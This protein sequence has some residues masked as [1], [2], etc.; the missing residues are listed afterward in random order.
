MPLL[1]DDIDLTT[2]QATAKTVDPKFFS[3][4]LTGNGK[5]KTG[6][7]HSELRPADKAG[8]T[9]YSALAIDHITKKASTTQHGITVVS[10]PF[11]PV[12]RSALTEAG[13][14]FT[15]ATPQSGDR[16]VIETGS[17]DWDVF[18]DMTPQG[19]KLFEDAN[20]KSSTGGTAIS[21]DFIVQYRMELFFVKKGTAEPVRA[22][23]VSAT[24]GPRNH[25]AAVFLK[26]ETDPMGH[27]HAYIVEV[28]R[29]AGLTHQNPDALA[30]W[31][32]NGF[33]VHDRIA[34]QAE[35]WDSEGIADEVNAY[36]DGL[37]SNPADQ[38]LNV[39]A[40]QL[41]YLETYNVPLEAY[42]SIHKKIEAVF[43]EGIAAALSKQNLN[44]LMSHT[45]SHLEGMKPQLNT[46]AQPL[47]PP[48]L[49]P[50]LSQQQLAGVTTHEPLV[51]MQA[52]AGTGKAQPLDEPV[53]TPEGWVPMGDL[54]VGDL[55]V[56]S[57]GKP[58]RI[59]HVHERG[60]MEGYQLTFRDGSSTR[61]C[62]DHL[63][64]LHNQSRTGIQ[65]RV[66]STQEWIDS[67]SLD[68]YFL[69]MVEAVEFSH[70]EL[71]L[72][73]Y[74]LGSLIAD[75]SLH[76]SSVKY[77]KSEQAVINAV[78]DA[79]LNDG[80]VMYEQTYERSTTRHWLFKHEANGVH[81]SEIKERIRGL[82]L[83]VK[84]REKFIPLP[85]LTASIEQRKRLVQGLF[86]GDA[87][88]RAGRG[89]AQYSTV[90]KQLADDVLQLLWSLGLAATK[91]LN[92]HRRG[93]D[94]IVNLLSDYDPFFASRHQGV[95]T[96]S[97]RPMRRM[98]V[99]AER[100]EAVPMRCI[101]VEAK[102]SLY[103]TKDYLVTHNSSVILERIKYLEAC[104]VPASDVTV[105]SF[106]NAAADNITAKNPD[107]GSMTIARMIND[108]Y[109]LNHP[110]HELS[111]I[112][113]IINSIDIFY[114]TDNFAAGLRM[115]LM[116]VAQNKTGAFTSL[117]TYIENH[118][119]EMMSLLD[120]IK[121]TSLE[122]EIIIAYQRIDSM[123]EPAHVQSK[124]LI[125]D[126]VQDNSIFEF[127]YVLKYITKHAQSLFIVGDASQTLY[128][129][130]S[131]NPRALN[132]L[133][134][135]GVFSTFKLTTNYR[136]NQEI[137][138]FANVVLGDL[139]TNQ[140][141]GIQLQANS[142]AVPTAKSFQEKVTLDYRAVPK[143]RGF[144]SEELSS[145]VMNTISR[146]VDD[147]LLRGEQVCFLAYSRIEVATIQK[148]LEQKYPH[149]ASL[150]SEKV[151]STDIFS[152]YIKNFWN[153]VL[154]VQ[155]A[156]AAFVVVQGI[157]DNLDKLTRNAGNKKVEQAVLRMVSKWWTENA[158]VIRGWEQLC[159]HGSL[160]YKEF[161]ER[162]RDNLL[163]FE[164]RHNAVRQSLTNQANRERKEKNA[165][166]GADLLVSTIHGAKGME[167][168]NVV[169]LHK[170]DT[171]MSQASRRE[172]YV[173]FTRAKKTEYILSYGTVKNP[174][175][176]SSYEQIVNLL[177]KR[178]K[179]VAARAAGIDPDL[180]DEETEDTLKKD[181]AA[182]ATA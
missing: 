78:H 176:E 30:D 145:I 104:G 81:R 117:N 32:T 18:F 6:L 170:E 69:P 101:T 84:S 132:T 128:E 95:V 105:L 23:I 119:D 158:P 75:G 26:W 60:L 122:L 131:A 47:T 19:A 33:N 62:G 1:L 82:G 76:G 169:V 172:F 67:P 66:K 134:G 13:G 55:V 152:K 51:M 73:P 35:I 127:I 41:R 31:L 22:P 44:L 68:K 50:E 139:E 96:G 175:I 153:D 106:T 49:R 54:N 109:K 93:N 165:E 48:A 166:S 151:F 70:K 43:S 97:V 178:D 164:I 159:M 115:R 8:N 4:K 28:L 102:D 156:N 9:A 57:D 63:W 160:S 110:T 168:D 38:Q 37:P 138:D 85:Y 91:Q 99:S 150:V 34:W 7:L 181:S 100:I 111:S 83:D 154:Q 167:F 147:C 27:A 133:E 58:T 146:Y 42:R 36:I 5:H 171:K 21:R 11:A 65:T 129:F 116:E 71:P 163:S 56:G 88:V 135:S 113:T 53:L 177:T 40:L 155:P 112:D 61:V 2:A 157:K 123:Q 72:D 108:I 179:Q 20:G 59:S 17:N 121:Q 180:L 25:D 124:Y 140:I 98:L 162:L 46:P 87:R 89:Y 86:D 29:A 114:P 12:L 174:P 52:G 39:L 92:K 10:L 24:T 149:V 45:L 126:E 15:I 141:A 79:A 143:L 161:F 182:L 3:S 173:A 142:L 130:R 136:S 80:L 16:C 77:A 125:I 120:T 118:F 107:V 74:L 144:V 90:S 64:T 137:L 103:V 94:W 14:S 148:A